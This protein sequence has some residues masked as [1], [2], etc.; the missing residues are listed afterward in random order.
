MRSRI[1]A[2]ALLSEIGEFTDDVRRAFV[3]L[4]RL[5]G[6]ESPTGECSPPIDVYETDE[7]VEVAVDL[8]GV[9]ADAVRIMSKGDT[10]L[11]V[12]EKAPRRAGRDSSF[13]LVERDY[14]RFARAVRLHRPC[15]TSKAR[16]T[17][18]GGEL[19]VSVPKVAD[20]RGRTIP[21]RIEGAN[22]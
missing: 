10:I 15:D 18:N 8:P 4:G 20:R 19:H 16:A 9:S 21:I 12:G 14:G 13:H 11:I 2:V 5:S 6:A 7:A 1:H 22:H 17:L 3:E